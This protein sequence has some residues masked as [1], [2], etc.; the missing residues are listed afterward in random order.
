MKS[1]WIAKY[2]ETVIKI[3]TNWF[4]GEKLYV[5][6]ELQDEQI[7]FIT[8][9]NLSGNLINKEGQKLDI[10]TNTS[11]FFTVSCR[12][13]IDNKKVELKQTK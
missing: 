6:N 2:E 7:N 13:F 11:G 12:L 10:K 1:E 9:S 4:S 5:N 8:P 3:T